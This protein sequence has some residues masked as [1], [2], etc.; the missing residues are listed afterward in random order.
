[1]NW[2]SEENSAERAAEIAAAALF[3]AAVAFAAGAAGLGAGSTIAVAAA[4]SVAV[5]A[6]L[7]NIAVGERTYALRDFEPAPL[8]FVDDEL[9]L[10]DV[11]ATAGRDA[12]VVRLFDPRRMPNSGDSR[13][14]A[15]SDA[16]EALTSALHELRRSLR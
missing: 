3:A 11:L 9:L 4:G 15:N 13:G 16:S 5:Y 8:E 2:A 7:T 14:S 10:D 6:V 1:M 12:R